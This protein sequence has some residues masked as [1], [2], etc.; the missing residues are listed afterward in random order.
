MLVFINIAAILITMKINP[1]K[2]GKER[3]ICIDNI[4]IFIFYSV[5]FYIIYIF[6][7]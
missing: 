4:L 2:K 7:I 6:R 5:Q 1:G 3:S